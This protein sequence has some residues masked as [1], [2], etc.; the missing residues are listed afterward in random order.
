MSWPGRDDY[1]IRGITEPNSTIT[2]EGL[3]Q[4]PS[5]TAD[6]DGAFSVKVGLSPRERHHPGRQRS[7]DGRDS[8]GSS[9]DHGGSR[10]KPHADPA[11]AAVGRRRRR[12]RVVGAKI[13]SG[14][15]TRRDG[16]FIV[17]W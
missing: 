8:A 10:G 15:C 12:E 1:T 11:A 13:G 5:T 4:N 14:R 6:A 17:R 9:N 7:A 16:G 3:R 2:T